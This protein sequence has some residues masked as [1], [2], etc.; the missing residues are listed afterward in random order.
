MRFEAVRGGHGHHHHL[1]CDRCGAVTPF[2]DD[3]LERAIRHVAE[4]VPLAVSDHEV[5]LHGACGHCT[6]PA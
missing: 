2:S 3:E 6:H 1:I 4:R 5:I